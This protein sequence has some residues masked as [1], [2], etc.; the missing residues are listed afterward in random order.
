M[1]ALP[2][3]PLADLTAVVLRIAANPTTWAPHAVLPD[4]GERRWTRL[5]S[6]G[7]ADVWLLS[8]LPGHATDLHDHGPS[9]AAFAVVHGVLHEIRLDGR[10]VPLAEEL[11]RQVLEQNRDMASHALRV[12]AVASR[13]LDSVPGNPTPESVGKDLTFVGLL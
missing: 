10:A 4:S 2:A 12:L 3:L 11:K 7:F 8:W 9:S 1:T 6:D 13:P 5:H